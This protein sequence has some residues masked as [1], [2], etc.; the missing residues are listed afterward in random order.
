MALSNDGL[1]QEGF[2]KFSMVREGE[3]SS[4]ITRQKLHHQTEYVDTMR[5]FNRKLAFEVWKCV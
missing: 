2:V 1:M 4:S 3:S 5:I